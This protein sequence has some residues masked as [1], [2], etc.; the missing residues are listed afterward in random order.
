MTHGAAPEGTEARSEV[1]RR[2]QP[3]QPDKEQT[4]GGPDVDDG[5]EPRAVT[6]MDPTGVPNLDMVLGG[7]LTRGSLTLLVGP[8]GSGKTTL[9]NQIAFARAH[10]G[11]RA[12]VVTALS[13]PTTKL[14]THLRSFDFYEDALVGDRVQFLSL[15]QYLS[16]SLAE[17][18]D[19]LIDI[20]RRSRADIVVLDGFRGVRGADMDMQ[21]AR[22]FLYDVGSTLSVLGVTTIITSEADPR[23]P[24]FFPESTTADIII[25]LHYGVHGMRQYRSLEIIKM[26]GTQPLPGL[27][28]INVSKSGLVVYP[29]LASRVATRTEAL[30][31]DEQTLAEARRAMEAGLA[32]V[33]TDLDSVDQLLG[34]G[35]PVGSSTLVVGSLGT[36]KSLFGLHFAV[37]GVRAGEPTVFLSFRETLTQLLQR[38]Q[39]FDLGP[40][41][42]DSVAPGGLLTLQ[43]WAPI[44]LNLEIVS[45]ELIRTI[46]AVG[47]RRLVID[48]IAE[49]ENALADS[50]DPSRGASYLGALI[51]ALRDRDVTTLFIKGHEETIAPRMSLTSGPL[52]ILAEN[53]LLFQRI[54]QDSTLHRVLSVV[55]MRMSAH[56][57]Q[58]HRFVI[59]APEGIVLLDPPSDSGALTFDDSGEA[60]R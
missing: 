2:Q 15:Q 55:K 4:I 25:G 12:V 37:A 43:H 21:A 26:R 60:S 31:P 34:G 48:S 10:S 36:G 1:S 18:S 23:D 45:D 19:T 3:G 39:P 59:R 42:L 58:P 22:Q 9:A 41:L 40:L 28:G 5:G 27:H 7:G 29:R 57:T 46:D 53:L 6:P 49:I 33:S 35:V 38:A 13:E 8:P 56:D 52:A 54:E 14:V 47:A 17:T 20:A 50:N 32:R 30:E 16:G 24:A 51:E 44:E 11:R